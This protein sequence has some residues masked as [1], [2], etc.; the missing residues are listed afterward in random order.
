MV[1]AFAGRRIDAEDAAVPRFPP[2]M[3]G[4]VRQRLHDRFAARGATTLVGSGA[5]GADLLAH[6][7]AEALGLRRRMVLPYAPARF[8]ASSVTDRPDPARWGALFDRLAA[9]LAG[10][11]LVVLPEAGEGD[12][13]YAAV[14]E[15]VLDHALLLAREAGHGVLAVVAW[16][17]QPR[18]DDDLTAAFAR[19][20]RARGREVEE[21]LTRPPAVPSLAPARDDTP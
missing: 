11:D 1:I 10:G 18:G 16:E 7:A 15:A 13:A 14:N 8:R 9:G 12:D 6:E 17:G 20:A 4:P 19:A 21:V 5:C 3:A 2:P